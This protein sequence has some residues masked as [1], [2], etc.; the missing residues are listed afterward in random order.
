M[1]SEASIPDSSLSIPYSDPFCSE[2]I[3]ES[4]SAIFLSLNN[5]RRERVILCIGTDRSTGDSLGPLVGTRLKQLWLPGLKIYGTLEQPIHAVNIGD[6]IE[7]IKV[8]HRDPIIIAV[9]ACLGKSD[10]VGYINVRA[11]SLFPGT[12]LKKSLP[13]VGDM[14]ISGIVNVGGYLEHLVL[15]N[16][17]LGVVFAMAEQIAQGLCGF[18]HT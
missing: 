15:Q 11:G 6:E 14:H 12:A 10:R 3:T 4:L 16:T 1:F 17:R 18:A 7:S 5:S 9:D 2:R 13:G 8:R